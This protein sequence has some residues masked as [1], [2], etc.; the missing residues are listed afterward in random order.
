MAILDADEQRF[1]EA[2]IGYTT[3]KPIMSDEEYDALKN[4]LKQRGSIVSAQVGGWLAQADSAQQDG[5]C[6][7]AASAIVSQELPDKQHEVWLA[8]L[9]KSVVIMTTSST[10]C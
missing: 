10:T 7:Q 6:W 5:A 1:L 2:C 9:H 3:G 8:G 4:E